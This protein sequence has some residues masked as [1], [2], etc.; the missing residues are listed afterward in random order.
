VHLVIRLEQHAQA[1][2]GTDLVVDHK[3]AGLV[4]GS[5][6]VVGQTAEKLA[7]CRR[8][9]EDEEKVCW[10][11]GEPERWSNRGSDRIGVLIHTVAG[12][13]LKRF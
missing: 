6:H 10:K 12:G 11:F 8:R 5:G 13:M 2:A 9:R 7:A 4:R 3:D 1:L